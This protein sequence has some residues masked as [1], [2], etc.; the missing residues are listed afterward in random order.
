[1]TNHDPKHKTL[2]SSQILPTRGN[3]R[4]GDGTRIL[5]WLTVSLW[6]PRKSVGEG[7]EGIGNE[8]IGTETARADRYRLRPASPLNLGVV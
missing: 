8:S 3:C 7:K 5:P 1:M 2:I 6:I 4:K